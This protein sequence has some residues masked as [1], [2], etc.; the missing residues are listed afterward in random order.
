MDKL[1]QVTHNI[2]KALSGKK[3]PKIGITFSGGGARA[4]THIGIIQAFEENGIKADFVAG[5]SGG[6]IIAALYAA[7]VSVEKM[8]ELAGQGSLF[9][10]YKAGLPIKGFTSLDYLG[11]LLAEYIG[12]D[13]F[14]ALPIP[15]SVVAANLLTGEK[16]ILNKGPL[17]SAIMASCAIPLLF[18]PVEINDQLYIDGGIFDNMPVS[19]LQKTCDLI[20]GVNVTPNFLLPIGS[21]SNMMSIGTRV[22]D[23]AVSENAHSNYPL[24]DVVIAPKEVLPYGILDFNAHKS[25]YEIGYQVGLE[26]IQDIKKKV[27]EF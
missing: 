21:I 4:V 18:N 16:E 26:Y 9:K 27:K 10:I 3:T 6:A 23:M 15:L 22:F 12:I 8:R 20:I 1:Q 14:E 2:K 7:G 25:L 17:Y 11:E 19:P 5:T 24:C 13:T